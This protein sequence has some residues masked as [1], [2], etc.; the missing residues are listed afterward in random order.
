[1]TPLDLSSWAQEAVAGSMP[2]AI[3]VALLAGLVSFFSPC[4][5]PLLPGYLALFDVATIPTVPLFKVEV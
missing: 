4:V 3:P 5:V 1:M 2:L